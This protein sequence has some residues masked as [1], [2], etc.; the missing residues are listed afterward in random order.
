MEGAGQALDPRAERKGQV[1]VKV[2]LQR[3]SRA[4][5]R[6]KGHQ[7]RAIGN[8]LLLLVGL[9]QGDGAAEVRW[10]ADKIAGLRVFNR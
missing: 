4:E 1:E 8:G 5:V 6:I 2:V 7:T 10:M 9:E 3:V